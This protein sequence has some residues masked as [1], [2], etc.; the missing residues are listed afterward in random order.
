MQLSISYMQGTC[1]SL[2]IEDQF[3]KWS[4]K[5]A[6]LLQ[7]SGVGSGLYGHIQWDWFLL[8][9]N[10]ATSLYQ[11]GNAQ[12]SVG[13]TYKVDLLAPCS[14]MLVKPWV[15]MWRPYNA[16]FLIG[17]SSPMIFTMI[18]S[19]ERFLAVTWPI[20]YAKVWPIKKI[21]RGLGTHM[22]WKPFKELDCCTNNL[23]Q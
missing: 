15:C 5:R 19:L 3:L 20:K 6:L 21:V 23:W 9:W 16:P 10:R 7:L 1:L 14:Q 8:S 22:K 12:G 11:P 2:I 4:L 17:Q 18:I 13:F